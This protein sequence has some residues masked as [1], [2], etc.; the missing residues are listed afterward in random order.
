MY[1][2][3]LG[4]FFICFVPV[5]LKLH[6]KKAYSVGLALSTILNQLSLLPVPYTKQQLEEDKHGLCRCC[7]ALT[8]FVKPFVDEVVQY[9]EG[10]SV[11]D[12]ED[13]KAELLSL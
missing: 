2:K 12:N 7:G 10:S 5:L 4:M 11:G 1:V 3:Y 6:G 13:L 9:M 8:H